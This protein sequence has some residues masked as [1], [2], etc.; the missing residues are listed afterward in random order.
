MSG[1]NLGE[2]T[3]DVRAPTYNEL[4]RMVTQLKAQLDARVPDS[5]MTRIVADLA[6]L[7]AQVVA[8]SASP[9]GS[10]PASGP[11]YNSRDESAEFRVVADLNKGMVKFKGRE[12]Q[13]EA[14]DWL[15]A[16]RGMSAVNRWPFSYTLQYVRMHVEGSA[17]DWLAGRSFKDWT[18]FEARFRT[19][20]VRRTGRIK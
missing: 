17:R 3:T 4:F 8:Q 13:F 12:T 18:E 19:T 1:P 14:E 6:D 16:V 2:E 10:F 5:D 11:N 20:F 7:R 15:L 9:S